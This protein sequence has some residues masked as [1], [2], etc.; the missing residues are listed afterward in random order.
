MHKRN[1]VQH[2]NKKHTVGKQ[3]VAKNARSS[4]LE[5]HKR[6]CTGAVAVAAPAVNRRRTGDVVPEFTV[7]KTRKSLGG[8][9][10]MFA[11]DM[12]EA[13]HLSALQ[14]GVS[15]LKPSMDNYHRNHRAY[16]FQLIVDV[17]FHKAVDPVVITQ[18]PVALTSEMVAVYAVDAPPLADVNRQLVNLVE[19]YEHSGSGWA[20]SNFSALRLTL[21]HLDPLRASAFVPLPRWIVDKKAVTNI[22]G[23]GS[24]FFKWAVLAGMHPATSNKPNSME[25]YVV[26]ASEYDFSSLCFSV[27]LSSI[28]SFAAKNSLSINVNGVEDEKKVIYPLRVTEAV[29]P[30]RH[31]DL[32]THER[33]GVQHY[34]TIKNFSRL[35]SSQLS[36]HDGAVYCCKKCLHAYT[37]CRLLPSSTY[38]IPERSEM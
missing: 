19:V 8:R 24:D 25:N 37:C 1:L 9:A 6:T 34:S 5:M 7:Q 15:T 22:I 36:R 28:A 20:F 29:L 18:P 11:V 31:V 4:N 38:E 12:K 23:T 14:G 3:P 26:Y 17:V 27:P 2:V 30:D 32:L 10:E 35:I 33:N 13:N 16:K 21:W